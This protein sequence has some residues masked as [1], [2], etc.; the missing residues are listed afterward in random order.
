MKAFKIKDNVYWVG[1]IDWNLR[2]FHGYTTNRGG[3]YNAYL[4]ID[5]K[6]TLIDNVYHPFTK[7]MISRIESIIDPSKIEVYISN[8]SEPDHSGSIQEILKV[9]T[10]AKVYASAPAGVK[11][12]MGTYHGIEVLPIKTGDVVNIGKRDL[13]FIQTPLV[14]WPDNMVTYSAY[15][16]ILFSNDMF[17][18]HIASFE[19]YDD[20]IPFHTLE[21]ELKKY[22]ANIILPYGSQTQRALKL[23]KG[24]EIELIAP[25]HGLMW[26]KY[27]F[28]ALKIY[29]RM[30]TYV[31]ENKA[32]IVYDSMWGSTELMANEIGE[33]FYAMGIPSVI[34]HVR[35]T[36]LS[37]I[38]VELMD[39][40]Y[41]AV[42]SPTL[43]NGLMTSI[44]SFFAYMK[45]LNP[46]NISYMVFGSYGWSGQGTEFADQELESMGHQ[47]LL[48]PIRIQYTPNEE[49]LKKIRED[50]IQTLKSII[51]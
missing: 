3:T 49:Q 30:S 10:H 33:A 44:A 36:P 46:K 1:V 18:Q 28:E 26:R 16:K 29:E 43:N 7:Q 6:V 8:H 45:G 47:R 40:K 19:R 38:L 17:G 37:D 2:D 11:S 22:Y 32:V 24:L 25:S 9:A 39:A 42:G 48:N 27:I 41:L 4:I 15:D 35:Q 50:L 5:E 31:K 34:R 21:D 20:Q 12:M 13:T 51:L 14:H 23:I